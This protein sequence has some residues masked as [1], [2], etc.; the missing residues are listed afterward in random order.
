MAKRGDTMRQTL[1]LTLLS[2]L[3][4]TLLP[5]TGSAQELKRGLTPED[6]AYEMAPGVTSRDV[7]YYSDGAGAFAKVF[8]P[9]DFSPNGSYPAVVLAQGWAGSHHSIAKYAARFAE[10]GFV[11]MAID[12]RGWGN[13]D[14]F[15]SLVDRLPWPEGATYL[16]DVRFTRTTAEVV[17]KRTRLLPMKQVEDI[18]NA[19]SFIQGEQGVDPDRIGVWGS[20]YAGGHAITVA[21][22]DTRVKAISV[23]IPSIAGRDAPE[24]PLG[25]TG[26][27]LR[28]A[29]LR[30][31]TGQGQEMETG[32]SIPRMVDVETN[33]A[34][35][36]YRP[37]HELRHIGDRPVQFIVAEREELF[38]NREHAY[39]AM[40]VLTGP[41]RLISVPGVTHFE[42]YIDDPF[43][44]SSGAAAE[45]FLEHL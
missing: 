15:V 41:K 4:S 34:A 5:G 32:F 14:G 25:F 33:E 22:L 29:I 8:F 20:S 23:Q 18:R 27:M 7:T 28:D 42:M 12:Y 36:D 26:E 21:A 31:R 45:W 9:P 43:E 40:E 2:A 1:T 35:R 17:V 37:F 24:G 6:W 19:I 38:D 10:F 16:D 11:A 39:S 13:S 3:A 44:I 30:A